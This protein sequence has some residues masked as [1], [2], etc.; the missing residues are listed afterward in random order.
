MKV[1]IGMATYLDYDGV[2]FSLAAL[3]LYQAFHQDVELLVVDNFGQPNSQDV[4]CPF[5]KTAAKNLGAVYVHAPH[6]K[7]T[8]APRNLVFEKATGDVVICIDSHVLLENGCVNR[9]AHF[10]HDPARKR[11]L[12]QGPLLCDDRKT[13]HTH[14]APVWR[15]RMLGTWAYDHRGHGTEP[16]PIGMQGLGMFAMRKEAW[17]GFSRHFRGFGGEE[18]Y[19][20]DK[21]RAAG[22]EC[23]CHPGC[24]WMHRFKRPA[25]PP[26]P[27]PVADRVAN[28]LIGRRELGLPEWDVLDHFRSFGDGVAADE[29]LRRADAVMPAAGVRPATGW[30][31][32][33]AIDYA[34]ELGE[35]QETPCTP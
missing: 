33:S 10:F 8:A 20:H 18:G 19:I 32:T 28:Y 3:R 29:G 24:R 13:L 23:W 11:D 6:A 7:G 12:L 4:G 30:P 34:V 21:V 15:K 22:G 5:T 27:M 31:Q 14:F 26:Y 9:V 2:Y 35:G 25:G 1:T 17:P 16:F